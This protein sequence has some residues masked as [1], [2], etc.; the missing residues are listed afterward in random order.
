M[1]K[2]EGKVEERQPIKLLKNDIYPTYQLYALVS[3]KTPAEEAMVIAV[4]ETF[5][6]L[7]KRFRDLDIPDEINYPEPDKYESIKL[8]DFKSFRINEGYVVDVVFIKEDGVWAF[9]LVEPDLGPQ[10]GNEAQKRKPAPGRVFAT[11][12]AFKINKD[13]N[14]LEC[15]FK[16]M[17]S[18]PEN[19]K[20]VCEVFRLAVVKSIIR[21]K[22]LGLEHIIPIIREPHI[23]NSTDKLERLMDYIR[24]SERQLP[25]VLTAEYK[26]E[27]DINSLARN[28]PVFDV[29]KLMNRGI[30]EL[31]AAAD[32]DDK[33]EKEDKED[34]FDVKMREMAGRR[35]GYAQFGYLPDKYIDAFNKGLGCN[36]SGG[37]VCAFYPEKDE[38]KR[39]LHRRSK[40]ELSERQFLTDFE[41]KLQE[42]P[43]RK[44]MNF[45]NVMFITEARIE[46]L[47]KIIRLSNTKEEIIKAM[48]DR[49][50]I[51]AKK[52]NDDIA[53]LKSEMSER[54]GKIERL[55]EDIL[56]LRD[57][58]NKIHLQMMIKDSGHEDEIND[59]KSII[60]W[61]KAKKLN[62]P[63]KSEDI[64][65]W[66]EKEFAGKL[67]FHSRA[68]GEIKKKP[69]FELDMNL[70]CDA[71]EY[72]ANEYRDERLGLINK[73]KSNSICSEKYGRNFE[74]TPAGDSSI[75]MYPKEYKVKYG[76]GPTGKS[77]EVP[78]NHHL[79]VGIDNRNIIR[80]YFFYDKEED[81]VVV[82]SLPEHLK[83]KKR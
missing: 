16:T 60:E 63:C 10:P 41:N 17:C 25:F 19:T 4:L 27:V 69:S 48:N 51:D 38:W 9:Q 61:W 30:E 82:G 59:L 11:N 42:Y 32:D 39:E 1:K 44:N 79:K 78:L 73:E 46:E 3:S 35:M 2:S 57:E 80:I 37:D 55:K 5:S 68:A 26:K 18:E 15:G 54:D 13:N 56:E 53:A 50:E 22:H 29:N 21:N 67:I 40:I 24:N 81:L 66:V 28:K 65:Q 6:W 49:I 75:E 71:I 77:R 34:P 83:C 20:V 8:D 23:I 36:I 33:E 76:K 58:L 43:K 72:L 7:R 70:L 12:I 14:K 31:M 74:V 64:P 47:N 52:H 45:D 62:H